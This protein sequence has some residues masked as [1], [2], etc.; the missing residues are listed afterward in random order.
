MSYIK[1]FSLCA[2]YK[3]MKYKASNAI[4]SPV[5]FVMTSFESYEQLKLGHISVTSHWASHS[6]VS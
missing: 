3:M 5:E 1:C 4:S 2:I 6:G